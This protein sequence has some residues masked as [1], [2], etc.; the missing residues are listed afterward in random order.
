MP[1]PTDIVLRRIKRASI[2]RSILDAA[3]R[4]IAHTGRSLVCG[5][6]DRHDSCLGA[7]FCLCECHDPAEATPPAGRI[8]AVIPH[9]TRRTT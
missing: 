4:Q 1:Y 9:D 5:Q 7:A 2:R 6:Y 3:E 8:A